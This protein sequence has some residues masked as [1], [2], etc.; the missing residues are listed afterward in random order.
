MKIAEKNLNTKTVGCAFVGNPLSFSDT[1]LS[2]VETELPCISCIRTAAV[3]DLLLMGQTRTQSIRLIIVDESMLESLTTIMPQ[4]RA[5]FPMATVALAFRDIE[6]ARFFADRIRIETSWGKVGFLP[7]NMNLDFWL[8]VVRLLA[9]GESYFP[10]ELFVREQSLTNATTPHKASQ[11]LVE[12]HQKPD[13]VHL[14]ARELQVLEAAAKGKQNKIIADELQ[15]SQHTV[16]LHM[17]H[18]IAKLGVHNRT[19][20]AN[21]YHHRDPAG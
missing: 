4:L 13:A 14:T 10:S 12:D 3:N 18:I 5:A 21:W 9:S 1:A 2:L 15:L 8:S 20:A 19:E 16:K 7:M 17:H 11:K 6:I